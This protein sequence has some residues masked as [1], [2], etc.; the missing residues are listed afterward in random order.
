ME[1]EK[2]IDKKITKV[3]DKI[4]SL[5]VQLEELETKKRNFKADRIKANIKVGGY[6]SE[7][8]GLSYSSFIKITSVDAKRDYIEGLVVTCDDEGAYSIIPNKRV[9]STISQIIPRDTF[10][11][12]IKNALDYLNSKFKN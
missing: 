7:S 4:D 6:F 2:S 8:D 12:E 3:L 5:H 11:A 9:Y 10:E 1:T